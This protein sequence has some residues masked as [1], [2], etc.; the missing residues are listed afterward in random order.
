MPQINRQG[1]ELTSVASG[2]QLILLADLIIPD[3]LIPGH[4]N[5]IIGILVNLIQDR[6][7]PVAGIELKSGNIPHLP[8]I[9]IDLY[10][11]KLIVQCV[12]NNIYDLSHL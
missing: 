9:R 2:R 4:Y 11:Q 5:Q 12:I 8:C 3:Q 7:L 1:T 6:R 10:L